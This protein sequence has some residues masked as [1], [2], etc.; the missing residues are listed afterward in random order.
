M[1]KVQ[2]KEFN[3][4]TDKIILFRLSTR[5]CVCRIRVHILDMLLHVPLFVEPHQAPAYHLE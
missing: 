4:Q 3:V 1:L 2:I 5:E